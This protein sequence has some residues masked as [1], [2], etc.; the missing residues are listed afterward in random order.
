[1]IRIIL[2]ASRSIVNVRNKVLSSRNTNLVEELNVSTVAQVFFKSTEL[3]SDVLAGS[4]DGQVVKT[5]RDEKIIV[6]R[7]LARFRVLTLKG[8]VVVKGV[9][10]EGSSCSSTGSSS[11]P[12]SRF[13][14]GLCWYILMASLI[15]RAW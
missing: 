12:W 3:S 2:I 8:P 14:V 13:R 1:M 6:Q 10:G 15:L 11:N 5:S 9:S 7:E 4:R